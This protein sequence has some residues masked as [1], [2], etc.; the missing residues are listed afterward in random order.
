[1][2]VNQQE[3]APA[4]V[5]GTEPGKRGVVAS[6]SRNDEYSFTKPTRDEITLIA[7]L[8]VLGDVHAGVTVKHRARVAADPTQPNLR[9]VHLIHAELHDEVRPKGYEVPAGGL[10]ENITTTGLNLLDLPVGTIL[11][12]GPPPADEVIDATPTEPSKGGPAGGRADGAARLGGLPGGVA[13]PGG[14]PE[15]VAVRSGYSSEGAVVPAGPAEGA[16]AVVAAAAV[17]DIDAGIAA[18]VAVLA[19]R[20][21]AEARAGDREGDRAGDQAEDPAGKLAAGAGVSRPAV[22][23]MGLRN[24]C[25]QINGYRTGLLKH[26]LGRD[27]RGNLIRKAGV[28]AVV[29][30]G[31]T[32]RPGDR[33]SVDLPD[34]PHLPLDRV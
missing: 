13:V 11:R 27:A 19:A 28:M 5:V 17:A 24:P 7:G 3:P 16:A 30:R 22:I 29:L 4:G 6:V 33:I 10:G 25:Q 18:V 20:I 15:G 2:G 23:I 31:G 1:M 34:S 8:G 9:Q 21:E 12:F 14:L 32:I 26:V